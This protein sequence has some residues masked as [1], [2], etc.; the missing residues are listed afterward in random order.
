VLSGG[1][2]GRGGYA[3]LVGASGCLVVVRGQLGSSGCASLSDHQWKY[4]NSMSKADQFL[5]L[6]FSWS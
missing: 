6:Y 1:G 2:A 5:T 4:R 3:G